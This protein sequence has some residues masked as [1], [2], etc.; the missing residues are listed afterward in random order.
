MI[1]SAMCALILFICHISICK[2]RAD[3][4]IT[5]SPFYGLFRMPSVF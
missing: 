2:K 3:S 5:A 4:V 1:P